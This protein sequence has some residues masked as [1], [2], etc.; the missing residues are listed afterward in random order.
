MAY[1][2][3]DSDFEDLLE[4]IEDLESQIESLEEEKD[5]LQN[6]V[7]DLERKVEDLESE[8]HDWEQLEIGKLEMEEKLRELRIWLDGIVQRD[9]IMK[10]KEIKDLAD[11]I[12]DLFK[13]YKISL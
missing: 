4:Q 5:D 9:F 6:E 10:E 3:D 13:K 7:Y 1:N 8:R 11:S 2:Y 12:V